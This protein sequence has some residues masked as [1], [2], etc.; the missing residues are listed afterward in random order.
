MKHLL[1]FL[2][3][4]A[5]H[6]LVWAQQPLTEAELAE[7]AAAANVVGKEHDLIKAMAGKWKEETNYDFQPGQPPMVIPGKAKTRLILGG[8]F[9]CLEA[10]SIFNGEKFERMTI[11]GHDNRKGVYTWDGYDSF[12]TYAVHAEGTYDA[13]T[14]TLTMNGIEEDP[15]LPQPLIF[16]VVMRFPNPDQID[17]EIWFLNDINGNKTENKLVWATTKRVK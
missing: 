17:Y 9:A 1:P 16:K 13:A 3:F 6:G 8:R 14:K 2:L 15:F 10:A 5:L 12:G 4:L 11:L 7:K